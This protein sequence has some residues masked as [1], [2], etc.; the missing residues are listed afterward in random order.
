MNTVA[1]GKLYINGHTENYLIE[2]FNIQGKKILRNETNSSVSLDISQLSPGTYFV[3][4]TASNA[5][6][7]SD[8]FVV[9]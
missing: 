5:R 7:I 9:R 4:V 6:I 1:N 3:K 8:K 2:L